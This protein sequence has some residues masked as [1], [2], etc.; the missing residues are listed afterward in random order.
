MHAGWVFA[1][2]TRSCASWSSCL[3]SEIGRRSRSHSHFQPGESARSGVVSGSTL[4][5][6]MPVGVAST[7]S[8]PHVCP[9]I[10]AVAHLLPEKLRV[11]P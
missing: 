1:A 9:W 10:A 11:L 7:L 4:G 6:R 8:S 2:L 3:S 5:T